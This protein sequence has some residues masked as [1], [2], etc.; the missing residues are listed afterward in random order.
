MSRL[1]EA[2]IVAA[3]LDAAG[4]PAALVDLLRI[5]K[6]VAD[7]EVYWSGNCD[8]DCGWDGESTRC[9]CGNRRVYWAWDG[10]HFHASE[11]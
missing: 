10:E 11:Y 9:N 8:T 6:L 1:I 5:K 7:G 2:E 3:D 4:N